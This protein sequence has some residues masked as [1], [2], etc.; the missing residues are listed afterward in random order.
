MYCPRSI[1]PGTEY[2]YIVLEYSYLFK[3]SI[4]DAII[5]ESTKCTTGTVGPYRI[6][7]L[8][9]DMYRVITIIPLLQLYHCTYSVKGSYFIQAFIHLIQLCYSTMKIV[10]TLL[11]EGVALRCSHMPP[12]LLLRKPWWFQP[13]CSLI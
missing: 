4:L 12:V 11:S 13:C 2:E 1:V 7:T 3:V 10:L 9:R 8:V 5:A 6:M